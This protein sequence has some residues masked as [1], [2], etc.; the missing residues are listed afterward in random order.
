MKKEWLENFFLLFVAVLVLFALTQNRKTL[1]SRFFA[2]LAAAV[3]SDES[4]SAY[5]MGNTNN[6]LI[7]ESSSNSSGSTIIASKLQTSLKTGVLNLADQVCSPT[8]L[9]I[10]QISSL[11]LII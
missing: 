2:F 8:V 1:F 7:S 9:Q 11:F 10:V 3:K 6:C 4:L 5:P